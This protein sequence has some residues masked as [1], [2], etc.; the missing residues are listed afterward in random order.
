MEE[1]VEVGPILRMHQ[2]Q[3]EVVQDLE[4][5]TGGPVA[6]PAP[7][8]RSARGAPASGSCRTR[9]GA[10]GD[11]RG[12]ARPRRGRPPGIR[13][14]RP[15]V[16]RRSRP[17][18]RSAAASAAS[19]S[20]PRGGPAA[21]R[22]SSTVAP[23]V[24]TS[25]LRPR[26][27]PPRRPRRRRTPPRSDAEVPSPPSLPPSAA[28]PALRGLLVHRLAHPLPDLHQR[29]ARRA[30]RLGFRRLVLQRL[31]ELV[32]LRRQLGLV[33]VGDLLRVV[34]EERV[35]LVGQLVRLVPSLRSLA[36]L[37]VLGGEALGLLHHAVD[38]VLR[39]RGASR[40][41]H[42]LL[43]AGGQILGAH[44][45][46]A[47]RIDVERHLDLRHAARRRRDPGQVEPPE[48]L[49][50][51]RHHRLGLS[52]QDVDLHGRL[53]VV[54]G[55]EDLGLPRRDRGVPLDQLG[56]QSTLGLHAQ[57]QGRDVQQQDVLH[58][59]LQD[60]RLDRGADGTRPRR[61]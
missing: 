58:V 44:V 35:D 32:V 53:V 7:P 28:G 19:S 60:A 14:P 59:A 39:E 43:L 22:R 21:W 2:R 24:T 55:R 45:H 36:A 8:P 30:Q 13:R 56:E 47:V 6:R 52:L 41:R 37:V 50:A 26:S 54:R 40:D 33:R 38:L 61:G 31:L 48:R 16:A 23:L 10:V 34:L 4:E 51:G 9:P 12:T 46:D 17:R 18:R 3:V 27:H 29:L 25:P 5:A 11:G 1:A 20:S 15:P 42:R 49:H 57:R